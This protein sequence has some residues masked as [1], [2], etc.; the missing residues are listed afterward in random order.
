MAN[1]PTF[2]FLFALFVFIIAMVL[3]NLLTGLAVSNTQDI[4]S[5]A[6]QLSLVSRIKLIYEIE[7]TLLQ[8]YTFVEKWP[9]YI[10]L[11]PFINFQ[12]SKIKNICLFPDT[13]SMKRIHVL[14]NKGPDIVLENDGLNKAED[15][16]GLNSGHAT[17]SYGGSTFR[18]RWIRKL[19]S[20]CSGY[21]TSCK[22]SSAI[23]G[24]ANRII[25]KRSESNGN[26]MRENFG[27]LQEALKE[28]L[29]KIENKIE[30]LFEKYQK[31]LDGI[32]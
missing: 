12:K 28:N 25:S 15:R 11:C 9:K 29:S 24:K 21:N 8:W 3:L 2:F 7:S 19:C 14:A 20:K 5:N 26:N 23:I 17:P 22:M 31:K 16:D 4:E 18:D 30:D 10:L 27:Q 6:E 32:K 1:S 13:S